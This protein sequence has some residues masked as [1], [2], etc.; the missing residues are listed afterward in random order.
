MALAAALVIAE[1][2]GMPA[3]GA[4]SDDGRARPA[5]ARGDASR[6]D[7]RRAVPTLDMPRFAAEAEAMLRR[8]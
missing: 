4:L 8:C 5:L 1:K 6:R 7:R 2:L 3:G